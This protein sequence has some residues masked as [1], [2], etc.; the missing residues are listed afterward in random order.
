MSTKAAKKTRRARLAAARRGAEPD[1]LAVVESSALAAEAAFVEAPLL[2]ESTEVP[3][4]V[5]RPLKAYAFD[6]SLGRFIGNEMTIEV[7]YEKLLPGPVGPKVAV[8]DYDAGQRSASTRRSTSTTRAC[9]PARAVD[10]SESDP[11]FHQQMVYAVVSETIEMFEVA[12][13]RA[14]AGDGPSARRRRSEAAPDD[15]RLNLY[16][17]AM[18]RANAYYS[19]RRATGIVFGYFRAERRSNRGATCPGQTVF[20]CLS[21]DIIAHEM[22]HAIIDGIRTYFTEPHQP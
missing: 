18:S 16:P 5:T 11:R 12:L 2:L 17:H 20:T 8:V 1:A 3:Q 4:P 9:S 21:H 6:P 7:K 22:T 15:I 10:P 19:P 13:G 14:S